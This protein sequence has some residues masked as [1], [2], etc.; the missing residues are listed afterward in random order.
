MSLE[1]YNRQ[2]KDNRLADFYFARRT[3]DASALA[4]A[5]H[6]HNCIPSISIDQAEAVV[7]VLRKTLEGYREEA[8][9]FSRG[10][11]GSRL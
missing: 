4:Q 1:D 3:L 8:E 2:E 9:Q 5:Y 7:A 11:V 10:K 6:L